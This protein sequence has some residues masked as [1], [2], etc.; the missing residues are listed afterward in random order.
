M[1]PTVCQWSRDPNINLD[2]SFASHQTLDIFYP[3][4][5][6]TSLSTSNLTCTNS[7]IISHTSALALSGEEVLCVLQSQGQA[8]CLIAGLQEKTTYRSAPF[9]IRW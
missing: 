2:L 5:L 3:K 4:I 6:H 7:D 9:Q 8:A 1:I